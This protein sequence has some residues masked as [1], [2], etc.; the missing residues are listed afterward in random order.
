M[1][2]SYELCL[3]FVEKLDF[4]HNKVQPSLFCT[5]PMRPRRY[6]GIF[7]YWCVLSQETLLGVQQFSGTPLG[8]VWFFS[9]GSNTGPIEQKALARYFTMASLA[10][11]FFSSFFCAWIFYFGNAQPPSPPSKQCWCVL[12]KTKPLIQYFHGPTVVVSTG[13]NY[14]KKINKCI[15]VHFCVLSEL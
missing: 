2:S 1:L 9:L 4:G 5:T 15:F 12:Y 10:L 3:V 6:H 13:F 14:K 11:S 8:C 7:F